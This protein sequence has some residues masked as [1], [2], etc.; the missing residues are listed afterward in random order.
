MEHSHTGH[1]V[2]VVTEVVVVGAEVVTVVVE[3]G[4]GGQVASTTGHSASSR[5]GHGP[6]FLIGQSR[7]IRAVKSSTV[8]RTLSPS[9]HPWSETQRCRSLQQDL[10]CADAEVTTPKRTELRIQL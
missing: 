3:V 6:A 1:E 4:Q 2:V 7:K 10:H 9:K 5:I 8:G